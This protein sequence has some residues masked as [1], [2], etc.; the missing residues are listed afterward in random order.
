M[1]QSGFASNL[2]KSFFHET[3]NETPLA[4]PYWSGIPVDSIAL[5]TNDGDSPA[6]LQQTQANQSCIGSIR[7]LTMTTWPDLTGIHSFLSS[8]S[9]KPAVG[10]LKSA[11]YALHYIHLTYNCG[12]TFTLDYVKPMHLYI[13]IHYPSSTDVVA[14]TDA[15][16]IPPKLS[17]TF[18]ILA[19]SNV[20]WGSQ[21]GNVVAEGTLL[22]LFKFH[23]INNDIVFKHGGPIGW[24]GERQEPTSLSSCKAKIWAT[25]ATSKKVVDFWNLSSSVSE[26]D[27]T[28]NNIS[29]PTILY[30]DNNACIKWLHNMTSKATHHIELC[31]KKIYEWVQANTLNVVH[32]AG[33]V[34]PVDIFTE[35]MKDSAH[36]VRQLRE[37]SMICLSDFVNDSC[38]ELHHSCLRQHLALGSNSF[39]RTLSNVSHLFSPSQHILE[40][41]MAKSILF[42]LE[43]CLSYETLS[44]LSCL[45]LP[46]ISL[47]S[48]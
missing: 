40:A 26:N 37:S 9:T 13:C 14:Y 5:S 29:S 1:N 2:I 21:I 4:T 46:K 15:I 3:P 20:C 10:C 33:K 42:S 11:L 45:S 17:T 44:F 22:P 39:C 27:H 38:L 23:S 34:N 16:A 18:T 24:I 30:N 12:T 47:V 32:I 19:Y 41:L 25:N 35:E 8:Y 48:H 6:Q 43:S 7:W 36:F 28:I 31:K